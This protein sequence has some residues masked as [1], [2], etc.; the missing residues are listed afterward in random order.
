M[1]TP[2][3]HQ[4]HD[5]DADPSAEQLRRQRDEGLDELA[6]ISDGTGLYDDEV[7]ATRL[8]R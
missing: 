4:S 5:A 1:D 2:N 3:A 6:R 7:S 8:R